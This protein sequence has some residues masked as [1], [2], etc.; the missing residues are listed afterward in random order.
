MKN[1]V[2]IIDPP[3]DIEL[4]DPTK[5]NELM[6]P[7]STYTQ[8]YYPWIRV[9]N[10]TYH[11]VKAPGAPTTVLVPPSGYGAGMWSRIDSKRGVWKAPAGVEALLLGV[12][13]FRY[14]VGDPQQEVLN[15]A[16]VN[17]M[18][19]KPGY[20]RVVWGAR[21]LATN[22]DPEWRYIPVRRTAIMIEE[23]LRRGIQWAVFEP[24]DDR[25][26]SS[27]RLS[28]EAYMQGLFRSGA[29]QGLTSSQAYQVQCG[30]GSTMDQGDIDRGYV[31]L[32]VKFRPLKPAEFVVIQIQQL[33]GQA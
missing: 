14:D 19:T 12:D 8:L 26:W 11:P 2:T 5:I 24:N 29:F 13:G 33:A 6:L 30:L 25:L 4:T 23:A 17:V 15:P 1:R 10:P 27:L 32:R 16:G 18:R 31:I 9:A 22:A 20:G 7:T 3:R 28:S 21:T